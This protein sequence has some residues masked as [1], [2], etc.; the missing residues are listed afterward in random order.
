MKRYDLQCNF[1]KLAK[2]QIYGK[3]QHMLKGIQLAVY[4]DR[5]TNVPKKL[6]T[7]LN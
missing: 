7:L 4:R 2:K 5:I 6:K 1:K 3:K